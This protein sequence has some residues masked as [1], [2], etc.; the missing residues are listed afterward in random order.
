MAYD[1]DKDE[2]IDSVELECENDK[3]IIT[4][5]LK[6][7]DGGDP[8]IALEKKYENKDGEWKSAKLG[9]LTIDEARKVNDA[10]TLL[11]E[12]VE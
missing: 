10:L 12:S 2:T 3:N 5:S 9:R 6:S 4:V 11:L 7:Y 8:K 1:S